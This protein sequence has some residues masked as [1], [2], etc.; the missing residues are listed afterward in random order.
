MMKRKAQEPPR[1]NKIEICENKL[2]T[3]PI[4]HSYENVP[5]MH[6]LKET[7][8]QIITYDE[9]PAGHYTEIA[10]DGI[11]RNPELDIPRITSPTLPPWPNN[12]LRLRQTK[13]FDWRTWKNSLG[14]KLA[15]YIY[16]K[17]F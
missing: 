1:K 4:Y 8:S 12:L 3:R 16:R 7:S 10:D 17:S 9:T 5:L 2:Y 11:Y 15:I 14:Q 13:R 6:V